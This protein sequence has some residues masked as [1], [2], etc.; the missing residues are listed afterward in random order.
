MITTVTLNAAIDKTYAAPGFAL[1]KVSRVQRMDAAAGGKGINVARVVRSLG[2]P[3]TATGYIAGYNGRYIAE[4][5]LKEGMGQDFVE[6]EGESRLC[7]NIIDAENGTQTE[8]LEAGPV[9]DEAALQAMRDKIRALA[10][11]S[12]YVV[13]SGSLP[14]GCPTGTYAELIA[15]AKEAGAVVALDTSG[16]A[17]LEG[18]KA[19]PFLI[20]PNEDE[21]EKL[22]GKPAQTEEELIRCIKEVMA[23]GIGCVIVTL[24]AKGSLFGHEGRIYRVQAPV[25]D[26]VNAVGS[27]DSFV[28]GTVVGFARGGSAV[29]AVRLGTACGTANALN[30]KAGEVKIADVDRLLGEVIV[31]EIG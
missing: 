28:A 24:G 17:L 4:Q 5:V 21:I 19:K 27:G 11:S 22:L 1:N 26:C 20:K 15:I 3:V 8:L 31:E 25:I 30:F 14:K 13:M 7:L 29:D 6:A 12:R 16:D 2:E 18:V 9:I 23:Q 10:S